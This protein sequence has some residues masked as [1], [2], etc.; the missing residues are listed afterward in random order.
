MFDSVRH[1]MLD[2]L[3]VGAAEGLGAGYFYGDGNGFTFL[4]A[5]GFFAFTIVVFV[6]EGV[7]LVDAGGDG[8]DGG[9]GE[10][11][12]VYAIGVA[13]AGVGDGAYYV[14]LGVGIVLFYILDFDPGT[15]RGFVIV[16]GIE[17]CYVNIAPGVLVA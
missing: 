14:V 17:H 2:F 3:E 13:L 10:F 4:E 11:S 9:G 7:G 1:G 8:E 15:R 16:F 5:D 12:L 6:V